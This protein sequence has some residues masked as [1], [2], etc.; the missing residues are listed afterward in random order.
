[1][2]IL[3]KNE[4]YLSRS[5]NKLVSVSGGPVER[6]TLSPADHVNGDHAVD[7]ES[8]SAANAAVMVSSSDAVGLRPLEGAQEQCANDSVTAQRAG[9]QQSQIDPTFERAQSVYTNPATATDIVPSRPGLSFAP[10][11]VQ[12]HQFQ[13]FR[14]Q[15]SPQQPNFFPGQPYPLFP[16][17]SFSLFPYP[18]PYPYTI[19]PLPPDADPMDPF[20]GMILADIDH[21]H[22]LFTEY[23]K[24]VGF[25][26]TKSKS[27]SE[28]T[29]QLVCKCHGAPRNTRHLPLIKGEELNGKVRHRDLHSRKTG[30]EWRAKFKMQFND[31][32]VLIFLGE[33]NHDMDP[34]MAIR[35]A[36]NRQTS[37]QG[38]ELMKALKKTSATYKEIADVVNATTGSNLLARDVYNRTKEIP[39][40]KPL[41]RGRPP[42]SK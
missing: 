39:R 9:L 23:A 33:H 29:Y 11:D 14:L 1:M 34:N 12:R 4:E 2:E 25:A 32:W 5:D 13:Q 27:S 8:G 21:I 41:K 6:D 42:S 37:E 22:K 17:S 16:P 40:A 15:T 38:I 28:R 31:Q 36:E 3:P 18:A 35:Y 24:R 30:C 26:I 10:P 20:V 7:R 19:P